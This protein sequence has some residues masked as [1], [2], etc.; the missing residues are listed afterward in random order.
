MKIND[1]YPA[2]LTLLLVAILVG[3]GLTV[4]SGVSTSVRTT[5]T[6]TDDQFT[7]LTTSCVDVGTYI[8]TSSA[9]FENQTAQSYSTA[10]FTWDLTGSRKGTC[11][12]LSADAACLSANNTAINTTYTYGASNEAQTAVDLGITS[13][14]DFVDWFAIIV[15]IIAAAIIIGL[16]LKSFSGR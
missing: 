2:V 15:V 13:T 12:T 9:S 5:A 1:M 14:D 6:A 7:A 11:V 3:V 10:C 4:L 8:D 16:V